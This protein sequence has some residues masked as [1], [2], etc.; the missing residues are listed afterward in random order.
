M[1]EVLAHESHDNDPDVTVKSIKTINRFA[2]IN[3]NGV[4]KEM[5]LKE[6]GILIHLVLFF[7]DTNSCLSGYEV[8]VT[9]DNDHKMGTMGQASEIVRSVRIQKSAVNND[10]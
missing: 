8:G 9:L 5:I 10:K 1:S 4:D 6:D 7:P 2:G 3:G